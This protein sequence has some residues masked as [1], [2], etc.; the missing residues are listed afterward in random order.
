M[1]LLDPNGQAK[2]AE[3]QLTIE[4]LLLFLAKQNI[5]ANFFQEQTLNTFYWLTDLFVMTEIETLLVI[6]LSNR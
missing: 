4:K 1:R 5:N 6:E 3:Q 2:L